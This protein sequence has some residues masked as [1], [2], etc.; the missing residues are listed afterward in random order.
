RAAA[1]DAG[2]SESPPHHRRRDSRGGVH[3][4]AAELLRLAAVSQPAGRCSSLSSRLAAAPGL[5]HSRNAR[6]CGEVPKW[7]QRGRLESV[8]AAYTATWVRIPPS[9]PPRTPDASS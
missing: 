7:S 2:R 1:I 6:T 8:L 4:P 5:S 9:P 3:V